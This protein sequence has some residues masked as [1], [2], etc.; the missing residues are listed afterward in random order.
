[1]SERKVKWV[2]QFRA[3]GQRVWVW[4]NVVCFGTWEYAVTTCAKLQG[5]AK[6]RPARWVVE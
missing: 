2:F 6:W 5:R 1:M 4:S 3:P